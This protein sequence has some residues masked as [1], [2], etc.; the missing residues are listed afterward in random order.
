MQNVKEF[1][2]GYHT[3]QHD[4]GSLNNSPETF[5]I[6]LFSNDKNA[7]RTE[8]DDAS[9]RARWRTTF[10]APINLEG[11]WEARLRRLVL[12]NLQSHVF[13]VE[14]HRTFNVNNQSRLVR[15][16]ELPRQFY[17]SALD[18]LEALV[19]RL[20]G[21]TVQ[22]VVDTV[23]FTKSQ[24][25]TEKVFSC[26]WNGPDLINYL[27]IYS[28]YEGF[29]VPLTLGNSI[30]DLFLLEEI[31]IND[32]F[33]KLVQKLRVAKIV[34]K[35]F[36]VMSANI[37][38][39]IR[40]GTMAPPAY[41]FTATDGYLDTTQNIPS[42]FSI[43]HGYSEVVAESWQKDKGI[44]TPFDIFM[45]ISGGGR[46]DCKDNRLMLLLPRAMVTFFQLD[47]LALIPNSPYKLLNFPDNYV[48]VQFQQNSG[49][50]SI[51]NGSTIFITE[52]KNIVTGFHQETF[53]L[54][55]SI[56][57]PTNTHDVVVTIDRHFLR[58]FRR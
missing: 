20:R 53:N 25:S 11:H 7:I 6:V 32:V 19:S 10:V 18:V 27:P 13:R 24:L 2:A 40:N 31:T 1:S 22:M 42:G 54:I 26:L 56:S 55:S 47:Q 44:N 4:Y 39:A 15:V 34:R 29:R 35:G 49:R 12:R 3:V 48:G 8:P 37:S 57:R 52:G 33:Q 16:I 36:A 21:E 58:V 9:V 46:W 23:A 5:T 38:N 43:R 28:Y 14:I 45:D 51:D 30:D 17:H 41:F 50:I